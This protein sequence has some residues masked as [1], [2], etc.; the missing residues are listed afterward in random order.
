MLWSQIPEFRNVFLTQNVT[1]WPAHS[2][3]IHRRI[4]EMNLHHTYFTALLNKDTVYIP[5]WLEFLT[6]NAPSFPWK[7]RSLLL[8]MIFYVASRKKN[9]QTY[10]NHHWG[11]RVLNDWHKK[12]SWFSS[13]LFLTHLSLSPSLTPF[14]CSAENGTHGLQYARQLLYHWGTSLPHSISL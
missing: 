7:A 8:K 4:K 11:Y 14:L 1:K 13:P 10:F 2:K 5:T 12:G 3:N 9:L 6:I